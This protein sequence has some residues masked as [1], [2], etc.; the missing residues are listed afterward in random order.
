MDFIAF[1]AQDRGKALGFTRV[2]PVYWP[3][4]P[5]YWLG[6]S[7]KVFRLHFQFFIPQLVE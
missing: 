2:L 7:G 4:F 1:H 6:F 5:A 3:W